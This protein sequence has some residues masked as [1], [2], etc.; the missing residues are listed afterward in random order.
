MILEYFPPPVEFD[1]EH[2]PGQMRFRVE[3]VCS[4]SEAEPLPFPYQVFEFV[5]RQCIFPEQHLISLLPKNKNVD[6]TERR[7]VGEAPPHREGAKQ[8]Y[9]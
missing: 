2:D 3:S 1:S 9:V 7:K 5:G 8:N 6:A 4:D